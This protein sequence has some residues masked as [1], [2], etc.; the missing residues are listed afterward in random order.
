MSSPQRWTLPD[1]A[2]PTYRSGVGV[3]VGVGVGIGVGAGAAAVIAAPARPAHPVVLHRS[4]RGLNRAS[5]QLVY[6]LVLVTSV[7]ALVDLYLLS[8]AIPR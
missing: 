7:I 8:T 2:Q 6:L 5:A 3:G 1:Y 4:P